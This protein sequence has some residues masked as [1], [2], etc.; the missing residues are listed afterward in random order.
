[1]IIADMHTHS[2]NSH[3]SRANILKNADFAYNNGIDIFAVTDHADIQFYNERN[4][5]N[6][7]KNSVKE[8]K[9][10]NEKYKGKVKV[11]HGVEL[12]ESIWSM[13]YTR[14][15]L[16]SNEFDVVLLSVHDLR[17]K[18]ILKP[19]SDFDFTALTREELFDFINK[20]FEY[21]LLSL[22]SVKCD[23]CAHLTLPFRYINNKCN[24]NLSTKLF[25]D[26]ITEILKYLI[27]NNIALEA[28]VS[29]S[30]GGM[31]PEKW[32]LEKYKALGGC[33]ITIGSDAHVTENLGCGI[34]ETAKLIKNMGFENYYY[35]EKR[36]P[37]AI[38]L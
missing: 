24:L 23:I 7:I 2:E 8:A 25:E 4:I 21:L 18:K 30:N 29:K 6:A 28:N 31:I 15:I 27:E 13:H 33:L 5:Y 17:T 22:K 36:K 10:A 19:F 37:I 16:D 34:L 9:E 35:Y 3:D 26:K 38:K 14:E 12:G 1:M 20:Y 11:L 32:I